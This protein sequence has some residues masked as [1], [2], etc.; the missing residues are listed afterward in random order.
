MA[1]MSTGVGLASGLDYTTL[2]SQLMQIE[3][4]PQQ[5]LTTKLSETKVDA[6]AYRA[7]NT[8]LSS[9]QSA[10]EAL[11]K[12]SA[13]TPAK[14]SSSSDSVSATASAGATTGSVTF[15]VDRLAAK[16]AFVSDAAWTP[17]TSATTLTITDTDGDTAPQPIN[18]AA[19]ASVQD[20]VNVINKAGA[21]VTATAVNTGS[22]YRLQLTSK[23]SGADGAFSVSGGPGFQLLSQGT[24]AQLTVGEPGGSYSF[25]VT[26]TSNTF[27]D[28]LSGATFTVAQ[29]GV[30]ATLTVASDPA[31]VSAAV[32]SLVTAANSALTSVSGFSYNGS[33]STAALRGDSALRQLASDIV[34]AVSYAV[35]DRSPAGAGVELTK[36]G[37]VKFTAETFTKALESDPALVQKLLN[38]TSGASAVAGVAQRLL[39]VAKKATDAT[40][41]TLTVLAKSKDDQ[42]T[43][44]KK[45]IDDWDLRL[46]LR[47]QT[48]TQ[49]FTAMESA[50]G[51]MKSQSSWLST[52]L[53]QLPS[54]SSTSK[55]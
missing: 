3:A 42:A 10:A 1:G 15:T 48:L 33:G 41:G 44:L 47:Q 54:W 22:G 35:D 4:Q 38:G 23:A 14:A 36:D 5:L 32:E 20:A 13:W 11:T 46:D 27:S 53:G 25:P 51:T 9:L 7:V 50:L 52:Q 8:A 18:I 17:P 19:G 6:A 21:G 28:L 2:I 24:D 45:R 12:A 55:S 49:Q 29:K 31:A 16:H 37:K 26:S 34:S 43:E 30:T 40:T 39:D